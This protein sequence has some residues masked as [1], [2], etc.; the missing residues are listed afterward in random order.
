LD[1]LHSH[2]TVALHA[3]V[4]EPDRLPDVA[5]QVK[6][7]CSLVL[8]GQQGVPDEIPLLE[9]KHDGLVERR[10]DV[11]AFREAVLKE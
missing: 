2:E 5:L 7:D 1:K 9:R 10:R 6:P 4:A 11:L 8:P 3:G